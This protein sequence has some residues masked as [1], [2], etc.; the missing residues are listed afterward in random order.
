MA[1]QD[2]RYKL[3]QLKP[4]CHNHGPKSK[5]FFNKIHQLILESTLLYYLQEKETQKGKRKG[6]L[7][8]VTQHPGCIRASLHTPPWYKAPHRCPPLFQDAWLVKP[9]TMDWGKRNLYLPHIQQTPT[10]SKRIH[11]GA[12]HAFH[13]PSTLPVLHEAQRCTLNPHGLSLRRQIGSSDDDGCDFR[14]CSDH[15]VVKVVA[16][17]DDRWSPTLAPSWLTEFVP[18]STTTIDLRCNSLT[19][20]K[21]QE[22]NAARK[23]LER[24]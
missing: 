24:H 22:Q 20:H 23:F 19:R 15:M 14:W 4:R 11:Y 6:Y 13:N 1:Y 2:I 3:N 16:G 5:M 7:A 12:P 10:P 18:N 8:P 9:P 17:G 21:A